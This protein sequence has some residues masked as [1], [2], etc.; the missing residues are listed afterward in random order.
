[1][2][3]A[4]QVVRDF[5]RAVSEYTGA[6]YVVSVNSCTAALFLCLMWHKQAKRLPAEIEIPKRTYVSVPMQIMHAGAGI[7]FRDEEWSG[8][9]QLAPLPVWD[10]ARRFTSNMY[11]SGQFICTSHHW[12]KLLGLQQG[13]CILHDDPRADSWFRRARFDGRGEGI[14]PKADKFTQAGWHC[15]LSPEIAALGLVRL[16]HLPKVNKDMPM[17]DYP[18][19][20]EIPLFNSAM[21]CE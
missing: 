21:V 7:K 8:V 5:E 10:A 17:G 1:M 9:Y 4:F 3:N 15:Y 14:A 13:G 20:S 16:A 12:T 2:V 6:P 18:D 11:D 19:L